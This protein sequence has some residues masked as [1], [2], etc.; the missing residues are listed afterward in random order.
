VYITAQNN[1]VAALEL[2]IKASADVNKAEEVR[3]KRS[4]LS[5]SSH[6]TLGLDPS[7]SSSGWCH[8]RVHR[9]AEQPRGGA[10]A[11]DQGEC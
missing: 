9:R 4:L 1:H 11:A 7:S 3:E 10:R 8:T 5:L 6:Y 2:L